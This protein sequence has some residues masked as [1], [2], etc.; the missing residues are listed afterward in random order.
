[1]K[2]KGDLTGSS[3][4]V[5]LALLLAVA[6]AL[7]FFLDYSPELLLAQC[8]LAASVIDGFR[9]FLIRFGGT[10]MLPVSA[11]AYFA[12]RL[13]VLAIISNWVI[14]RVPEWS[15]NTMS[16]NGWSFAAYVG[17]ITLQ[18]LVVGLLA[19]RILLG[20]L[21]SVWADIF[22]ANSPLLGLSD[23][24]TGGAAAELDEDTLQ[25]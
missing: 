16:Y 14:D 4:R 12:P 6:F 11:L 22:G 25:E 2:D 9:P 21:V 3:L 24:D 13:F 10:T 20:L 8:F 19:L 15:A 7:T 23:K 17:V 5:L 18:A 1:M